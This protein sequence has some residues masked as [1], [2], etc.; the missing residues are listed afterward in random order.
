MTKVLSILS[1]TPHSCLALCSGEDVDELY[2]RECRYVVNFLTDCGRVVLRPVTSLAVFS[3]MSVD[4]VF[5]CVSDDRILDGSF[6]LA[7]HLDALIVSMC[8]RSNRPFAAVVCRIVS[9][10]C[11]YGL[12]RDD[13]AEF[14]FVVPDAER[15]VRLCADLKKR[16]LSSVGIPKGL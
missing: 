1:I 9:L 13:Y 11:K 8:R 16:R 5:S 14:I 4:E 6:S 3:A 15:E 12:W 2:L 7:P 10:L